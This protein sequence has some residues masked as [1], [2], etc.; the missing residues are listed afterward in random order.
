MALQSKNKNSQRRRD[1]G[2]PASLAV[3]GVCRPSSHPLP[4][5]FILTR[6][7]PGAAMPLESTLRLLLT[8]LA[9]LLT[10]SPL[11]LSLSLLV[12]HA[13]SG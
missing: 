6:T 7:H 13:R 10:I 11:L 4:S 12:D 1:T 2:S 5:P 8:V 3:V 9:R